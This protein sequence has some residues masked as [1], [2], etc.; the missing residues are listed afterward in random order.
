[1][2][3]TFR[4]AARLCAV[5]AGMALF[6]ANA[7]PPPPPVPAIIQR[8]YEAALRCYKS[9]PLDDQAAWQLGRACFDRAEFPRD[10]A[11]RARV[12][13]EGIAACSNAVAR[14]PNLAA[15]HYYLAMNL[16]QL[17]RTRWLGA[18]PLLGRMEKE[19]KTSLALDEKFDYAGA[20]RNLGLLYRDSPGWPVSLGDAA[21][22]R[23]HLLRAVELSPNLPE[24]HINLIESYLAWG[25]YSAAASAVEKL[26]RL[27]PAARKELTGEYWEDAW[28]DWTPRLSKIESRL[29]QKGQP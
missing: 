22:A 8:N 23:R 26:R 21:K 5:L 16:A 29:K 25:E 27:W 12:A 15:A 28:K 3:R 11:E 10:K 18:L 6:C 1:M 2:T 9:N 24:N 4:P 13:E 20:D 19:W 17:A 14:Q 7:A